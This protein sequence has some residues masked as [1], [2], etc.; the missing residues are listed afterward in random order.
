ML[1]ALVSAMAKIS[2]LHVYVG[3]TKTMYGCANLFNTNDIVLYNIR[4]YVLY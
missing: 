4:R 3:C 1:Q 2:K